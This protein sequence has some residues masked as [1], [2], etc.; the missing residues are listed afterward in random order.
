M[1]LMAL[2][3]A[4][5]AFDAWLIWLVWNGAPFVPT[6]RAT[7]DRMVA[8]AGVKPGD[9]A[10]DI[11][12]G[13]GRIVIALAK[14]GAEAHGIDN[15]PLLVWWSRWNIR[16]AGLSGRAFI[17]WGNFWHHDFS[18]YDVVTLFGI[19]Q[20]MRRLERKL[21]KEL[22]PGSRVVSNSFQFPT[23]KNVRKDDAVFVYETISW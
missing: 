2:G 11:G 3:I 12:S 1:G 18:P 8:V 9:R 5:L 21:E 15:N 6:K 19:T 16:K 17:H 20:I 23:W 14:A 13:D 22:K 4:L 10:L 7:V